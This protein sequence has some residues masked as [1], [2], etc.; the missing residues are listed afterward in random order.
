M[1]TPKQHDLEHDLEHD[2]CTEG[3]TNEQDLEQDFCT[4]ES[5]DSTVQYRAVLVKNRA[6]DRALW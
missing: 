5:H 4:Q 3:S 1:G 6:L 2:F